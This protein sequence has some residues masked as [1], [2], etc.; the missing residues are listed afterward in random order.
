MTLHERATL[1]HSPEMDTN[2]VQMP[3]P[4]VMTSANTVAMD[5]FETLEGADFRIATYAPPETYVT[6]E[7][8]PVLARVWDSDED[9]AAFASL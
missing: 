9:D 8:Y 6:G 7:D 1:G 3:E 5:A 4:F 2:V